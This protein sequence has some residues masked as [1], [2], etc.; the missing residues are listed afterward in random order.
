MSEVGVSG[1]GPGRQWGSRPRGAG[2]PAR[3]SA[4]LGVEWESPLRAG[5][6][7]ATT[8]ASRGS[9]RPVRRLSQRVG[10]RSRSL[11]EATAVTLG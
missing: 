4:L 1:D 8:G 9:R 3:T 6:A 5:Q 7:D 10:T 11:A 2:E